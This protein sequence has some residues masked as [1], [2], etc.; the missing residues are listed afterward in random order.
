MY[1]IN[2]RIKNGKVSAA[3]KKINKVDL[4]C[5]NCGALF[6]EPSKIFGEALLC[7]VCGSGDLEIYVKDETNN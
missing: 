5:N 7:A 4:V 6:L 3:S 1:S 2:G